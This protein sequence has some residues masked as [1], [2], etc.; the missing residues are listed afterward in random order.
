ME[1]RLLLIWVNVR[2]IVNILFV[3]ILLAIAFYNVVGAGDNYHIKRTPKFIIAL[4]AVNF[5]Y[6]AA[7]VVLTVSILCQ[8]RFSRCQT[9]QTGLQA[10]KDD[11]SPRIEY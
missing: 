4:I 3:F 7:K 6:I 9:R 1:E 11:T 10:S 8:L 2:N 5:T